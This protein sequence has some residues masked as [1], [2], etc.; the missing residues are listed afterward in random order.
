MRILAALALA[1]MASS[2][3]GASAWAQAPTDGLEACVVAAAGADDRRVLAQW[4]F[5]ALALHP[6]LADMARVSDAQR[7]DASRRMGEVLER[8]LTV[9]CA[10]QAARAFRTGGAEMAFHRAFVRVGQLAGESLF[11]DPG[12]AAAGDEVV[13]HVDIHRIAELLK[14]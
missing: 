5:S 1:G 10:E 7:N 12:V 11:N 8:F 3:P 4:M 2:L 6:D 9:D 13:N 14:P